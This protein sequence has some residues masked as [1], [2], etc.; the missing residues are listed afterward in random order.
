MAEC[1]RNP[2]SIPPRLSRDAWWSRPRHQCAVNMLRVT[3]GTWDNEEE[4]EEEFSTHGQAYSVLLLL[5]LGQRLQ[6]LRFVVN[7]TEWWKAGPP[8]C[9]K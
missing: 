7:A 3:D 6:T 8:L 1:T 4:E 9:T 5:L 2:G